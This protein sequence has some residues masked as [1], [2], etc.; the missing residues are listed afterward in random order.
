MK[1][2]LIAGEPS[3]DLHGSNL[4]RGIVEADPDA[5][6][7]F[8]GG[9]KMAEVGGV[10][11]LGLHYRES[12]FFG[13]MQVVWNLPTILGQLKRCKAQIEAFAPDVVI[14]IDYAGFNLKIA[15]FAKE[16]GILSYYYIAPKV[17]AWDE[18]RI[19]KI[20]RYVDELFVI[21][22]FETEYFAKHNIESHFEGNPLVDAIAQRR[23]TIPSREEFLSRNT[24]DERP[25]VALIAGSRGS[26]IKINLPLMVIA[27]AEFPDYQ[28]VV[29]GV[30]WLPS[31]SYTKWLNGSDIRLV[32][33]QTYELLHHS[34]AAI[35]TSGTATLETALIGTPQVVLY[36]LPWIQDL[37]KSLVLKIPFISL[38]NINLGRMAVKEIMQSSLDPTAVVESLRRILRGGTERER[39]LGDY[40]TLREIIGSE[41]ASQRFATRMVQLLR[42]S[43]GRR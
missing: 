13:L 10:E 7:R 20:R 31:E 33:S 36:R 19:E 11:N 38:V 16:R 14:L 23:L 35:V 21:F 2:F 15:R 17:W 1:Y 28:F 34:E 37:L 29:A 30:D 43:K 6:F 32:D 39:V 26:E 42:E 41:R 3:G 5:E 22:P 4:M 9:D 25:I 12:S 18:S 40:D 27:A 24:L 8:W